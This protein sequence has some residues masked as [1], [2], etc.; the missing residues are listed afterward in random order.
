MNFRQK[1][2]FT[3]LG[4]GLMFIGTIAN[5]LT[6]SHETPKNVEFDTI[7]CTAIL[8]KGYCKDSGQIAL[9]ADEGNAAIALQGEEQQIWISCKDYGRQRNCEINMQGG[10][11]GQKRIDL[12]TGDYRTGHDRSHGVFVTNEENSVYP[13]ASVSVNK[14]GIGTFT[15]RDKNNKPVWASPVK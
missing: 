15:S 8:I 3:I 14:D 13:N 4:A 7:R 2:G 9:Y 10:L 1:L 11:D 5:N 6:F 12:K